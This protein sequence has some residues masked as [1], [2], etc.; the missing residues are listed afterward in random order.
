MSTVYW[1]DKAV[2]R[3]YADT[4]AHFK[5][6]RSP[7]KGKPLRSW[8]RIFR[9]EDGSFSFRAMGYN[10]DAGQEIGVLTADDVF[11]FT[12]RPH[13]ARNTC[14]VTLAQS[15]YKAIPIMWQRVGI[16]KYRVHYT[17]NIP[18]TDKGWVDWKYMRKDAPEYFEGIKF[19]L[20]TGELVNAMPNVIVK[21]NDAKRK[22]WLTSLR[23]FKLTVKTMAKIGVFDTIVKEAQSSK[24]YR[25]IPEWSD[26]SWLTLLYESIRDNTCPPKLAFAIASQGIHTHYWR[27][28]TNHFTIVVSGLEYA[29]STYSMDLRKMFGVFN[30]VSELPIEDEVPGNQMGQPKQAVMS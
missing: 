5:T 14:A 13:I 12:M 2:I 4:E 7:A 18:K 11:T 15:L 23:K 3:S 17:G 20:K 19:N 26:P 29:C 9:N 27:K 8:A 10:G 16:A 22:E 21:V 24:A 30:E 25:Q 6:C 1:W 28:D